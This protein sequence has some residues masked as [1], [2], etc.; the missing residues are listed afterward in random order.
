MLEKITQ[1]YKLLEKTGLK[2]TTKIGNSQRAIS[3]NIRSS[4]SVTAQPK[5]KGC[6]GCSRRQRKINDR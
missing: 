3:V 6:R 5:V 2:E 4:R 1:K